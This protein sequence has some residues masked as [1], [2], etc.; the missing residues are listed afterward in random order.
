VGSRVTDKLRLFIAIDVDDRI[1]TQV[2]RVQNAFRSATTAAKWVEP[3][4]CHITLNFLGY[5]PETHLTAISDVGRQAAQGTRAFELEF[6][7]VGAFPNARRARV[8]WMGLGTG[9]APLADLRATL[10]SGL[11]AIGFEP[12]DR[13]FSPHLTL[14]RLKVPAKLEDVV[15]SFANQRFGRVQVADLR[16]MRSDLRPGGPIY[17]VLEKFPL[18]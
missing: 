14:A 13:P 18:S 9:E 16:L 17:S 10:A 5:V 11:Q 7:G 3:Q 8:L 2:A 4:L 1:R 15:R 6:R 12:E